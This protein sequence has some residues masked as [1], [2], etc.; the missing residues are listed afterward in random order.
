MP[1]SSWLLMPVDA[2]ARRVPEET[3]TALG[4]SAPPPS[5][6]R[7]CLYICL[8]TLLCVCA[9]ERVAAA[10]DVIDR[11]LA[12]AGG[13]VITLSD[14]RAALALGRVQAANAADPSRVALT[15]LIDR[16]LLL[17]EVNRFAPPEPSALTID[18]ALD[19]VVARFP[20]GDAFDA[21]LDRL[22]V[23][24][25]FVRELLREDLRIR[26]YLDQRFTAQTLDEQRALVD[27]WIAGLR[28]RSNVIDQYDT[29]VSAAAPGTAGSGRD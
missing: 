11:V 26:A 2:L 21:T 13:E 4:V 20:S 7:V 6:W 27:V 23:D 25:A 5:A 22:G 3:K 1:D 24:R 28:R 12:V 8:T 19:S 29:P 14:V 15:Q 16:A 9:T 17:A 10:D 18:S